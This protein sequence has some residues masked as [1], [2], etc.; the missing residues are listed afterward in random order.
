MQSCDLRARTNLLFRPMTDLDAYAELIRRCREDAHVSSAASLLSWDEETYMPRG[1]AAYRGEQLAYFAGLLHQ[2]ATDPRVGELLAIVEASDLVANPDSIEAVN[3]NCI[4]MAF[5]RESHLPTE[6][7]EESARI[8][9]LVQLAWAD[10]HKVADYTLWEPWL[11]RVVKLKR[12][13]AAAYGYERAYDGLLAVY[14]PG[15][16]SEQLTRIFTGLRAELV[17]IVT[18]LVSRKHRPSDDVLFRSYD[19]ARQKRFAEILAEAVG[20][21]F[22]RGRL[23]LT[24]HPFF[25]TNGPADIRIASR[26]SEYDFGAG[27]FSTLH[28][29]GHG[30][31]EQGLDAKHFGEP[32]MESPSATLHESQARLWENIVGRCEPFW[33]YAYPIAQRLFPETL[34]RV[35]RQQFHTALNIVRPSTNRVRADELTYNLHILIRFELEQ[36]LIDGRLSAADLPSAWN[37]HYLHTLGVMPEND[38][39][40]CLQ[41]SHWAAGMFGYFPAYSLGN[42]YAAQLVEHAERECGPFAESFSHGDFRPLLTWLQRKVHR[43][44]SRYDAFKLLEHVTGRPLDHRPF[45]DAIRR[46]YLSLEGNG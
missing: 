46:R 2:R 23:D 15:T 6:L 21:D 32:A 44:G 26:F 3:I 27:F 7:V 11:D 31:Y 38:V 17:P 35:P 40:G 36:S 12:E 37:Q 8:T 30:L 33:Q 22:D 4:R 25:S 14:D 43:M 29:V 28:E 20:F 19:I 41:D 39:D 18:Q 42:I 24:T 9:P 1:A 5:D 45:V 16:T 13:E 34:S 10:A